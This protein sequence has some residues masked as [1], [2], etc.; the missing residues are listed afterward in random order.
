MSKLLESNNNIEANYV[1]LV[2]KVSDIDAKISANTK[3][4]AA[5]KQELKDLQNARANMSHK[6]W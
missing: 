1:K 6:Q 4:H 2:R 5:N 3:I